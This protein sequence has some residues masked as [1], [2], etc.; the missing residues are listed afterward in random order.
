[1]P[2]C[3]YQYNTIMLS[4]LS[5]LSL[6]ALESSEA[7]LSALCI[8]YQL[9]CLVWRSGNSISLHYIHNYVIILANI[10]QNQM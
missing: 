6:K 10:I 9:L 4:T 2:E 3:L 1:M 7:W 5:L 8:G